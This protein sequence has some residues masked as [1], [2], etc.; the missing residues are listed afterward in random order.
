MRNW[1]TQQITEERKKNTRES[2]FNEE[3]R[4]QREHREKVCE[5][6]LWTGLPQN[7]QYY[8]QQKS[9]TKKVYRA[10]KKRQHVS[11]LKTLKKNVKE[12]KRLNFFYQKVKSRN[13]GRKRRLLLR[14]GSRSIGRR[15]LR[16]YF[17]KLLNGS[18]RERNAYFGR[19]RGHY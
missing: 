16:K 7:E 5:Q 12:K 14:Q 9:K 15:R 6:L 19:G 11:K 2:W 3:Y 13:T 1:R 10:N 18:K 17:I 4:K 8:K